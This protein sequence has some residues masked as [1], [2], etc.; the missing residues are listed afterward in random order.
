M[1][2]EDAAIISCETIVCPIAD[3]DFDGDRGDGTFA[4]I[5]LYNCMESEI[6]AS[7]EKR[8][9]FVHLRWERFADGC[10][11]VDTRMVMALVENQQLCVPNHER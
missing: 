3:T 6:D 10:Y 8:H 2:A 5:C 1:R 11:R 7:G 9:F 4:H